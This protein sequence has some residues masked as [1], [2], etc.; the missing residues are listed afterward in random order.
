MWDR[1]AIGT[2]NWAKKYNGAKVSVSD[3]HKILRYAKEKGIRTIDT[4]IAYGWDW[5][6]IDPWFEV[7]AKVRKA[8]EIKSLPKNTYCV[9]AH[10]QE[11]VED[12]HK[13]YDK[14]L[15]W[16]ISAYEVGDVGLWIPTIYQVPYSLYDRRFEPWFRGLK[17]GCIN[18]HARSVFLRGKILLCNPYVDKVIIGADS[19]RQFRENLGFLEVWD[20]LKKTDENLLDARKW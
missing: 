6:E 9:M 8:N 4:A 17:K 18:I 15:A 19:Y 10:N 1:I 16:G 7:I 20:G 12:C 14:F 5:S 13:A 3:Q 2:A 11:V